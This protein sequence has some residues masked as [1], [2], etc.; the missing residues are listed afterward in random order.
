MKLTWRDGAE[1]ALAGLVVVIALAVTDDWGW[2]LL[3][4]A[5]AGVVALAIVGQTMCVVARTP[6]V[7]EAWLASPR[8]DPGIAIAAVL[9][10]LALGLVIAG[11]IVGTDA[12]LLALAFTLVTLWAVTTSIHA[13][14]GPSPHPAA[15]A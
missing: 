9:G 13:V 8:K 7:V 12:V 1:T 4:S 3:G 14:E 11:L 5:R 15:G 6:S 10:A 2:P